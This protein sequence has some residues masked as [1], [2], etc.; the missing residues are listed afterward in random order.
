MKH[1]IFFIA[2]LG[3]ASCKKEDNELQ[4]VDPKITD[5][6]E[7]TFLY[8]DKNVTYSI[9]KK[10]YILD[11]NGDTLETAISKFWLDRNLG[12]N[13]AAQEKNDP[14]ASGD[15]YQ[16]GRSADGHQIRNSDTIQMLSDNILP[17]HSG[18]IVE[19]L[20]S[21]DWLKVSND[22]LWN[23]V[24]N[25]NCP[26]PTGWRV[27]TINELAMEMHSWNSYN[28]DGAYASKLKWVAGGNRDNHGTERY[29][30]NWAF[31]WSSTPSKNETAQKLAIIGG[32]TSEIIS[33]NRIY[34]GSVR[35]I[36]DLEN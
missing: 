26:C 12:A 33:S 20:N 3:L 23:G 27:P 21:N 14:L 25:T 22:E 1:K 34:G 19:P 36:K 29:S 4:Q 31:I 30:D 10:D 8:G 13:R 28:M 35:C 7:I 2:L 24:N 16:W 5:P 15:L 18:F 32:D 17:N 11:S 6:T 9:I